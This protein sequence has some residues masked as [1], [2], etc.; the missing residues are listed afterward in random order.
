MET[1]SPN[2]WK[3]M[4]TDNRVELSDIIRAIA[5]RWGSQ[6]VKRESVKPEE[7]TTQ[8]CLKLLLTTPHA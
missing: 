4:V 8:I 3:L 2:T 1:K 7:A 5:N 6:L